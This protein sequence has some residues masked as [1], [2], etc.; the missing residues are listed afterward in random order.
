MA[1]YKTFLDAFFE[2]AETLMWEISQKQG[3][4]SNYEFI[5]RA[6]QKH[7]GAYV[8]LLNAVLEHRGEQ[9]L[10]N[11]AHENIGKRLSLAAEKLGYEQDKDSGISEANIWGD[12][13]EAVLYR[14]T[15]KVQQPK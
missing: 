5:R 6:G 13:R 1:E 8:G 3:H 11:I 9:Y 12:V 2:D 14:R 4:F 15:S 10:F 7:Q